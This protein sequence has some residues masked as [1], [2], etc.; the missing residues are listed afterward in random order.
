MTASALPAPPAGSL[1]TGAAATDGDELRGLQLDIRFLW[2]AIYRNRF[3]VIGIIIATI[4][5][6]VIMTVVA[7]RIYLASTTVQIEQQS[8]A[9]IQ[10]SNSSLEP[11]IEG[12]E[13]DR[14]LQTQVDIIRSRALAERVATAKGFYNND[15]FVRQMGSEPATA[16]S[17][18]RSLAVTRHEQIVRILQDNLSVDLPRTS[19][20]VTISFRSPDP[21]LAQAVADQYADSYITSNL[22]RRFDSSSYARNFLEDQLAI[23]KTRLEASE[24]ATINYARGAG[25]LD[26]SQGASS[27]AGGN[28]AAGLRSLT[29]SSLVQLNNALNVARA[30]RIAAEQR[31]RQASGSALMS[32]PEIQTNVAIQQLNQQRAAARAALAQASERYRN[33]HPTILQL[34]A[35]LAETDQ[36]IK[37]L[38]E[39]VRGAVREQYEIARGEEQALERQVAGLRGQTLAEQD[40]SVQYNILKREADTNRTMYDALLQRY[41]EVSAQ[42][43]VT[44]NNLSILDRAVI[45]TA[46]VSPRP[47]VNLALALFAGLFLSAVF[48]FIRERFVDAIRTPEEVTPKLGLPLLN[49]IPMLPPGIDVP[50][51][52]NNRRSNFAEAYY[53][54]RTSIRLMSASGQVRSLLVTSGREQEGKSTTSFAL[55]RAFSQIGMKVLLIDGDMRRPSLHRLFDHDREHGLSTILAQQDVLFDTITSTDFENLDFLSSGPIPPSPTELLSGQT[56]PNLIAAA[57]ERYQLIIVDGPPVLGLADAILYAGAIEGTLYIVASGRDRAGIGRDGLRRLTGSNAGARVLGAVLTMF[58]P[59]QSGYGSEYGYYYTYGEDLGT[60]KPGRRG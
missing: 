7:T 60:D 6:G 45:P 9:I 2:A 33:D 44:A 1:E 39:S 42:A 24:R 4:I 31:W 23:A 11:T 13:V 28:D 38:A 12:Q 27:Q 49:T 47:M 20:I 5:A 3:F 36:Q 54:L 40:R 41:K 26:A 48:V 51:A 14:F 21:E 43:G 15:H 46:P 57:K 29:T 50:S 55:A 35:S 37:R 34:T 56:L 53:A 16:P 32:L 19:R 52:L 8:S 30:A 58:D 25:L 10:Q 17:G 18:G 22:R 59:K